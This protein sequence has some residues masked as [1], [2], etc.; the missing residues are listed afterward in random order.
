MAVVEALGRLR[1]VASA[2][3][4]W[5]VGRDGWNARQEDFFRRFQF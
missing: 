5:P 3:R 1:E 4:P 2:R